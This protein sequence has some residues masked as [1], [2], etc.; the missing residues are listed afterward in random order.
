MI[1]KNRTV[2]DLYNYCQTNNLKM[3][4][5]F[6]AD[7]W[8]VYVENSDYFDRLFCRTYRSFVPFNYTKTED[9]DEFAVEWI[10][11]VISF[12]LANEK[13]YS[14]LWRMQVIPD[15]DYSILDNYNVRETHSKETIENTTDSI[16]SRTDSKQNSTTY[17]SSTDEETNSYTHGEKSESGED[18]T[19]YGSKENITNV[20]LHSGQQAN[21]SE[22]R[23]SAD[24]ESAYSPKD[25]NLT[26]LGARTDTTETTENLGS[27]T[28]STTTTHTTEE[29]TDSERKSRTHGQR[30]DTSNA[31]NIY[32]AHE[33]THETEGAEERSVTKVGNMG[34]FSNSKLLLEH[35]ELWQAF[36]FYKLI[37]DELADQFLRI[38]YV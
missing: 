11:D 19:I 26:T 35:Q 33:N 21:D 17:G 34:I 2:E 29:H 8:Q 32:G 22:N 7:F 5:N 10:M 18:E 30:T 14:E 38:I 25:I 28:D 36:S 27:H 23:V 13:R 24:N 6:D 3:L 12:L 1:R 20:E 9:D 4:S 15:E 31:T 37:F 16:G